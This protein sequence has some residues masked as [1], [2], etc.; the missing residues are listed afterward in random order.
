[1]NLLKHSSK[2]QVCLIS[3]IHRNV[4]Q[5]MLVQKN[6]LS[7]KPSQYFEQTRF[8]PQQMK[9]EKTNAFVRKQFFEKTVWPK[10][11]SKQFSSFSV[12]KEQQSASRRQPRC[13]NKALTRYAVIP[14]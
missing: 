6:C 4:S 7:N 8:F 14:T 1:M 13:R 3:E 11:G 10:T 5:K 2:M 12:L 9:F